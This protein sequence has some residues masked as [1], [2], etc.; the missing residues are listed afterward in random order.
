MSYP[1][2]LVAVGVVGDI[3]HGFESRMGLVDQASSTLA[4]L[5]GLASNEFRAGI[6]SLWELGL[7]AR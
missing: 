1:R 5:V 2:V 7:I 3:P 6:I 4:T